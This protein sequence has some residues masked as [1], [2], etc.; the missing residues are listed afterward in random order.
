MLNPVFWCKTLDFNPCI[1][2][3]IL[4][5]YQSSENMS[6]QLRCMLQYECYMCSDTLNDKIFW[7]YVLHC[8]GIDPFVTLAI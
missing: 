6:C 4:Q 7:K 8:N 5:K 2:G 3:N 1:T